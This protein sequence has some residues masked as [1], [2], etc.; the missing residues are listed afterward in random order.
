MTVADLLVQRLLEYGVRQV[1]GYPGGQLTP[2]YDALYRAEKLRHI[3]ARDE[4]AAAFMADGFARATGTPGV[5]LAVCGPGVLN[6]TTPL[7]T[8]FTDS[9]P[10]LVISGQIPTRGRGLRSGFYH[11]NEQHRV[12]E[13][14]V[15][16]FARL[17][18]PQA[19][20]ATLDH[21]WITIQHGRPGPALLEIPLDV[22]RAPVEAPSVPVPTLPAP[23]VPPTADI[24]ALARLLSTWQRPL[25]LVG[26]GVVSSGASAVVVKLAESLGCPIFYTGMGKSAVPNDHPLVAGMPWTRATSDVRDMDECFSPLWRQADGLLALGCRFTQLTTGTWSMPLPPQIAQIDIDAAELGRHYPLKLGLHGDIR[27]SLEALLKL[28]PREARPLWTILPPLPEPWEF[29]QLPV[30]ATLHRRL[31]R[32]AIIVADVTRLAYMMMV[33]YPIYQPRTFSHPAGY[34]S[35]GYGIPA[36]IATRAA[37]PERQ[38]V[39]VL[40]DGGFQMCGMELATVVQEKLPILILLINDNC[41]TLIKA[42]Q[43]RRFENRTLGVDLVNPDFGLF[44]QAFGI[45]HWAVETTEQLDAALKEAVPYCTTRP[46]VIEIRLTS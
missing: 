17:E 14:C 7:A 6:A 32:D 34:V 39:A 23:L 33:D 45:Q 30:M 43:E 10:M 26:G 36:A 28:M 41:L 15:K 40:G 16:A 46:G 8:A 5:S 22:L 37:F 18:D 12:V 25:L 35:M 42:L 13:S 20:I 2:L 31:R 24:E 44:S 19:V 21:L 3:L 1:F 9:I 11:E 38:V 27:L 29:P 4:Q